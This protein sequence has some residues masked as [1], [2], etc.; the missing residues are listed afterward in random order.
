MSRI[1]CGG[2][3]YTHLAVYIYADVD[4]GL[5]CFGEFFKVTPPLDPLSFPP[6]VYYKL[7]ILAQN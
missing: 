3:F 4:M 6:P 7:S 2:Y 1:A 5:F